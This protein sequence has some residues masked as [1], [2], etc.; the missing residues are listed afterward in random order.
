MT[1]GLPGTGIGGLFY[2]LLAICMPLCE[3]FRT[4]QRRTNIKRWGIITL[5]L[6]FVAGILTSMWGEVWLLNRTL[7][8]LQ[9]TYHINLLSLDGQFTFGRTKTMAMASALASFIS[10]TF[11]MAAVYALRLFV[12]RPS[13]I[14]VRPLPSRRVPAQ[15][16]Y[17]AA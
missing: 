1:A 6:L 13:G 3:I 11:V 17:Q 9:Q 14:S 12:T 7:L 4:L 2:L 5:Q 16:Q 10:L 8:W 15:P